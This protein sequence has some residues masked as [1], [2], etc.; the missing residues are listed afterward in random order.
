[1]TDG[2]DLSREFGERQFFSLG[3]GLRPGP[4]GGATLSTPAKARFFCFRMAAICILGMAAVTGLAVYLG[5][6]RV[7][8]VPLLM[9]CFPFLPLAVIHAW[10]G[11][12]VRRI[13]FG[14]DDAKARVTWGQSWRIRR[15]EL[16]LGELTVALTVGERGGPDAPPAGAEELWLRH[17]GR[18]GSVCLARGRKAQVLRQDF[19]GLAAVSGLEAADETWAGV[20]LPDGSVVRVSR[21]PNDASPVIPGDLEFVSHTHAVAK[22][23]AGCLIVSIPVGLLLL[24]LA[25]LSLRIGDND[26][27]ILMAG[28]LFVVLVVGDPLGLRRQFLVDANTGLLLFRR[29][30]G[31]WQ[32]RRLGDLAAL[33]LCSYY[34]SGK[35]KRWVYQLNLVERG[36]TASRL[37]LRAS[38]Q[39]DG[40]WKEARQLAQFLRLPIVNHAG[41][42]VVLGDPTGAEGAPEP[43]ART[44]LSSGGGVHTARVGFVPDGMARSQRAALTAVVGIL[45]LGI[46]LLFVGM[47]VAAV[48]QDACLSGRAI[49]GLVAGLL[50][51]V[52]GAMLIKIGA[53]WTTLDCPAGLLRIPRRLRRWENCD[54]QQVRAVQLCCSRQPDSPHPTYEINLIMESA[55][56]ERMPFLRTGVSPEA[57][58]WDAGHVAEMLGVPLL[59]HTGEGA[60]LA[61]LDLPD[62]GSLGLSRYQVGMDVFAADAERLRC[63]PGDARISGRHASPNHLIGAAVSFAFGLL[64]TVLMATSQKHEPWEPFLFVPCVAVLVAMGTGC[65][66]EALRR[67]VVDRSTSTL[68]LPKGVF[69][70]EQIPMDKIAAVQLCSARTMWFRRPYV[71]LDLV[72]REEPVR[73]VIF[74]SRRT[75]EDARVDGKDLAEFLG[76]PLL[77]H[78][79]S[80]SS[81]DGG[82]DSRNESCNGGPSHG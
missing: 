51:I 58:R 12:K 5:G 69:G 60:M 80:S 78:T 53:R 2:R 13:T 42:G 47:G 62:G 35:H 28:A 40:V 59:D 33:Q 41:T 49:V 9:S 61:E 63:R 25:V 56:G 16:P 23:S 75:V 65:L 48:V 76:V 6:W 21:E 54:L 71:E 44:A 72:L 68:R 81:R 52:G 66:T 29:R 37:T 73:R 27:P 55:L 64:V 46:G 43:V 26:W 24:G 77:D 11:L 45:P 14:P 17:E 38:S 32:K 31:G 20:R 39:L 36:S 1:M 70:T 8:V 4:A 79:D 10:W 50:A 22:T 82:H 19:G 7:V 57:A 15:V 18:K 30:F 34:A 3:C 67:P 74:H